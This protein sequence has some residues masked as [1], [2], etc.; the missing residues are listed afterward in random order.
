[1]AALQRGVCD[2]AAAQQLDALRPDAVR[3]ALLAAARRIAEQDAQLARLE[4]QAQTAAGV[5][6]STPSGLRP[7]YTKP[8]VPPGQTASGRRRKRPGPRTVIPVIA[9]AA[10]ACTSRTTRPRSESCDHRRHTPRGST[11]S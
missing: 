8:N 10:I 6:P 3:L 1:V 4:A 7:L 5:S 9:N 11:N 2:E